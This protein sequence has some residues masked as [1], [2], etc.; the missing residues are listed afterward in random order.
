MAS[1]LGRP[2]KTL[3]CSHKF[4]SFLLQNRRD[5]KSALK[6]KWV[7][8]EPVPFN[9]P[10]MTGDLATLGTMEMTQIPSQWRDSTEL[11]R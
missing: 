10:K 7:R 5:F 6:I 3:I 11:Q 1:L 8:P 9:D 4:T 2:T